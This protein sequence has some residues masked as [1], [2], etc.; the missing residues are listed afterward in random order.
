MEAEEAGNAVGTSESGSP[1][2]IEPGEDGLRL[3]MAWTRGKE[4]RH[5]CGRLVTR[6]RGASYARHKML[7]YHELPRLPPRASFA[8]IGS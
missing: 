5:A 1:A 7:D 6:S 3:A 2:G 8:A 4:K